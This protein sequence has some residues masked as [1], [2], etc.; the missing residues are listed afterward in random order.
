L[1]ARSLWQCLDC[2]HQVSTTAGTVLHGTRTPL[3]YWFW[4]AYLMTTATPGISALQLQR[5][6]GLDRYETAWMIL[7]KL[8]R[9]MVAPE[10][11]RLAG[12]VEID[13]AIIGGR[14]TG[15]GRVLGANKELVVVG[16]EIRGQ[17]SG[18]I[19][20][21]VIPDASSA[22]LCAFVE[23]NVIAGSSVRTD[24]WSGY[25]ALAGRG[26][27]HHPI[28]QRALLLNGIGPEEALPRAHRAFSNLKT[29]LQ[30][31]HRGIS[32]KHLQV[33][34]DEF[35][36]RFNRR[37]TPMAAFQTLLGLSAQAQPTTYDEVYDAS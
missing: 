10:R 17:G 1:E 13:E 23:E 19:R 32:G 24:G 18:R 9:A 8:R 20:L 12:P 30:G 11:T 28:S 7:Q 27:R 29:W 31:T 34:L 16:V 4:A 5:Q 3:Q 33:Y 35:V 37:R 26:F 36:F 2:R 25:K 6:L 15:P 22:A 14:D 21:K